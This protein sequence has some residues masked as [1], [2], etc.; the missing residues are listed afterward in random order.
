MT[1][2]STH[3]TSH[4][5]TKPHGMGAALFSGVLALLW[6]AYTAFYVFEMLRVG[7]H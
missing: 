4:S 5:E 1:Y 2:S 7:Q 6:G 3:S